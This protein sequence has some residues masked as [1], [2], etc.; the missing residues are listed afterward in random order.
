MNCRSSGGA[1]YF[2]TFI[3]DHSRYTWAYFLKK[4]ND[5]FSSSRNGRFLSKQQAAERS[6]YYAQIM[7]EST[8]RQCLKSF[9]KEKV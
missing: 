4:K 9:L 6:K 7:V 3:D 8:L 1:E 5:V 2:V